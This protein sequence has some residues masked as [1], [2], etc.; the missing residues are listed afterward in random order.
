MSITVVDSIMGSGKST[1]AIE[2]MNKNPEKKYIFV[3]PFL[4]EVARVKTACKKLAFCEPYSEPSKQFNFKKLIQDNR[5][6]ATTHALFGQLILTEDEIQAIRNKG[7]T[8]FID[9]VFETVKPFD[10]IKLKD[11]KLLI[12]NDYITVTEERRVLPTEKIRELDDS[13]FS[14][15]LPYIKA[16]TVFMYKDKLM[17]W[18]FPPSTLRLS[19]EIYILTYIFEASHLKR[20]LEM[21]DMSY[22]TAYIVNGELS[23]IQPDYSELKQ[24]Y[25]K[26]IHVY[27]GKMNS[28][29]EEKTALSSTKWKKEYDESAKKKIANHARYYFESGATKSV[30]PADKCL[31]AVYGE[32]EKK[33]DSPDYNTPR[34]FNV[35]NYSMSC[36]AFN[37]RATNEFRERYVLAYLVN[38]FEHLEIK[39]WFESKNV[40]VNDDYY[41]LSTMIQWIWR[42]RI[43]D[44]EEIYL[45]MPSKRMRNLL[46]SW[47]DSKNL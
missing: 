25:K 39:R 1:W 12:N 33:P 21:N 43:R 9:E 38:V 46:N 31:W 30:V 17:F 7:Y 32:K 3:T 6:I 27:S 47:L 34:E 40:K 23:S 10:K 8:L 16:G 37:E 29:G 2:Y 26:L 28:I 19:E 20:T 15:A 5:N 44:G 45:Y 18:T 41:A 4:D 13:S 36:I 11:L 42:S 22:D 14:E 35:P 24:Q